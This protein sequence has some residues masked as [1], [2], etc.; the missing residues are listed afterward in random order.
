MEWLQRLDQHVQT[1]HIKRLPM[2]LVSRDS[3][4][5]A[6]LTASRT[7]NTVRN[8]DELVSQCFQH[9]AATDLL[10]YQSKNVLCLVLS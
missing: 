3:L 9:L 7:S 5:E 4:C 1:A 10:Y 8:T 2:F 6:A